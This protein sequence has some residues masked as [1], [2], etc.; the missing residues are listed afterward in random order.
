M[1]KA[2]LI[3]IVLLALVMVLALGLTA[4][5]EKH[6]CQHV[7][8]TCGKCTSDCTDPACA[9]KCPGHEPEHEQPTITVNPAAVEIYAG[10]EI[11]LMFGVTAKDENGQAVTVIISDDDDFDA[12][13]EGTYTITYSATDANGLTAT[14]TRTVTVN[15]ALSALNLEVQLNR[16]GESKWQGNVISF[17]NR[18]YVEISADTT[19]DTAESGV[20]KNV[21]DAEVTLSVGGGTVFLRYLTPTA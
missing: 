9:D 13:V 11:D 10:D 2:R 20:W 18:L 8:P 1:K 15:K 6:E 14:A 5:C 19:V 17:A 12:D 3:A 21:S 7:C 4:A 16:L